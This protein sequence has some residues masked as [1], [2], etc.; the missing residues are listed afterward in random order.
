M[1]LE[2]INCRGKG[3]VDDCIGLRCVMGKISYQAKTTSKNL[4]IFLEK[5]KEEEE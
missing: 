2:L 5:D 3:Y 4:D 1:I